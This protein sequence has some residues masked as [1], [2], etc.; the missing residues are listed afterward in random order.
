MSDTEYALVT[1]ISHF[2]LKYAIPLKE[3]EALNFGEPINREKL[4]AYLSTGHVK[5]FS[6][7]HLGENV[8]DVSVYDEQDTLSV[9]DEDNAYLASWTIEQK[10]NWI[11]RWQED[12]F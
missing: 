5:E 6:Q 7:L 10:V 9:F 12:L 1:T 2:R 8:C 4:S 3:F 11:Q